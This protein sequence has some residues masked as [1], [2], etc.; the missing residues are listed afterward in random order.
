MKNKKMLS[1]FISSAYSSLR[2]ERSVVIDSLLDH[3]V[4]PICMEHF[5][6]S[7]S[8]KFSEIEARIDEADFLII[9]LGSSYGSTDDDGVSWTE[10]EYNYAKENNKHILA[11]ICDELDELLKKDAGA[12]SEDEAKQVRFCKSVS[13]ARV[14]PTKAEIKAAITQYISQLDYSK[15]SGWVRGKPDKIAEEELLKWQAEHKAYDLGGTWYH[16][17]LSA[18]DEK[19]IRVG[20]IQI[21]Q[22]FEPDNY[23]KL[24]FDGYNYSISGYDATQKKLRENRIKSSHW[25]GD[26]T[27]DDEGVMFGI[28]LVKREFKD[29]FNEQMVDRGI[30]RGIHD[31]KVDI[32]PGERV[33]EFQG[34]FH[35]E[36]PSP[37]AGTIYVFRSES[38][39]LEFLLSNYDYLLGADK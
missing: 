9:L 15:M 4:F 20:A 18:D 27:I 8:G 25:W 17:H 16:V 21:T 19:Y 32:M 37:K 36:A 38:A 30:R 7:A 11:L 31:F 28:F 2:D 6:V 22:S 34:E 1:A 23:R 29:V 14:V 39:R 12:L 13:F 3:G 26:Y 5:T 24:H 10:R 33:N 35:D